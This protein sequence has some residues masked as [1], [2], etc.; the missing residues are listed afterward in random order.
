[1]K[2]R[3]RLGKA[4]HIQVG[5]KA[6]KRGQ[7]PPYLKGLSGAGEGAATGVGR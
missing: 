2:S 1:M 4:S 5:D 3:Q 7:D 6:M